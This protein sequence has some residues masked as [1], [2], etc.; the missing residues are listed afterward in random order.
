MGMRHLTCAA[1]LVLTMMGAARAEGPSN[2]NAGNMEIWL[3][4]DPM[5]KW[6]GGK[7]LRVDGE[8]VFIVADG[9]KIQQWGLQIT[10]NSDISEFLAGQDINCRFLYLDGDKHIADCRVLTNSEVTGNQFL[11]LLSWLP[12]LGW[13]EFHCDSAKHKAAAGPKTGI[14]EGGEFGYRCES[15][16]HPLRGEKVN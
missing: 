5:P 1:V 12:Q 15:D 10:P 14:L 9:K 13:A 6:I 11:D 2:N 7:V 8:G 3:E 4:T 16:S